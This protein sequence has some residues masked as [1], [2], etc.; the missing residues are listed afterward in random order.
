MKAGMKFFKHTLSLFK[1]W[2]VLLTLVAVCGFAYCGFNNQDH[3]SNF[4]YQASTGDDQ[5]TAGSGYDY[6]AVQ[7]S[8]GGTRRQREVDFRG[9]LEPEDVDTEKHLK[10]AAVFYE[11][12]GVC[13][14][15]DDKEETE[16]IAS[17]FANC[18][19]DCRFPSSPATDKQIKTCL[20]NCKS[21]CY[22]TCDDDNPGATPEQLATCVNTCKKD[23]KEKLCNF[24]IVIGSGFFY[25]NKKQILTNDH[26]VEQILT[27]TEEGCDVCTPNK[28]WFW[29][30]DSE[31]I[32]THS[33][34]LGVDDSRCDC[35]GDGEFYNPYHPLNDRKCDNPYCKMRF[36]SIVS[37][38]EGYG[39]K[40]RSGETGSGP[41]E[42]VDKV[43]WS[44]KDEDVA[45]VTLD[46]NIAPAKPVTFGDLT[47]VSVGSPIFTIGNPKPERGDLIRFE[48]IKGDIVDFGS[49]N[50]SY[51]IY[52]SIKAFPGNSGGGLFDFATGNIIGILHSRFPDVY[53]DDGIGT[54][55]NSIKELR[56]NNRQRETDA[57]EIASGELPD[58]TRQEKLNHIA[59]DIID[60][61]NDSD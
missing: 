20:D 34:C 10:E 59:Q 27:Y 38:F 8:S 14:K 7:G 28:D 37:F 43:V 47:D 40:D 51:L 41:Y 19:F 2:K 58:S 60:S 33:V 17:D 55:I 26:I 54:H 23:Q 42:L 52:H 24:N 36:F 16:D 61:T 53:R 56:D 30:V 9:G 13:D 57:N 21:N 5:V 6:R 31:G 3:F 29:C 39:G 46:N 32:I 45:M 44:Y 48:A 49:G 12:G 1:S 25:E 35:D 18:Y 15:G 11:V 4:S 22:I 50:T